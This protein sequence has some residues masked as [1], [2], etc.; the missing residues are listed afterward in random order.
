[1]A[2][3][4]RNL[5]SGNN[6]SGSKQRRQPLLDSS[7]AR[8]K[9]PADPKH[10]DAKYYDG[11][12]R[13]AARGPRPGD[14]T[15]SVRRPRPKTA[16]RRVASLERER[17]KRRRAG[18]MRLVPITILLLLCLAGGYF[19]VNSPFFNTREIEVRGNQ[20]AD[21]GHLIELSGL[22]EGISIFVN[23][24][25]RAEDW[26]ELNSYVEEAKVRRFLPGKLIITVTERQPLAVVVSGDAFLTL[27]ADLTI[28]S[29]Q[30]SVSGLEYPLIT[31]VKDIAPGIMPGYA[32]TG[33]QIKS[34]INIIS[35]MEDHIYAGISEIN[36]EDTQKVR[37]Y[38]DSGVEVRV[39]D[40]QNFNDKYSLFT[41][42]LNQQQ[43]EGKL[44]SI[45]YID[46]SIIDRPVIFY[47][48]D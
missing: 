1:M 13:S 10:M 34:G 16:P 40:S 6:Q 44:A 39:G 4:R 28:L 37:I 17:Q 47:Y 42:I 9:R 18:S 35:Q 5:Y 3:K 23:Q 11:R 27:A 46:V 12:P 19:F 20:Y 45:Q 36:V 31:G 8:S 29:R 43:T 33:D 38:L 14:G 41:S 15:S 26:L 22:Q 21:A 48:N 24:T 25:E 2:D 32:L 7:Q 30:N